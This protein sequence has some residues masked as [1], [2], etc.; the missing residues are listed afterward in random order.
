VPSLLGVRVRDGFKVVGEGASLA[1]LLAP[2]T[3][4]KG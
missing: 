3:W 2:L 4:S 1:S